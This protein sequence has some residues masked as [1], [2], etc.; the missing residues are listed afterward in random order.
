MASINPNSS[1]VT[2]AGKTGLSYDQ[3]INRIVEV[4]VER[5]SREE[6]DFFKTNSSA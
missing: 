1:F 3:L 4:A 5:Y 6:P 2:A